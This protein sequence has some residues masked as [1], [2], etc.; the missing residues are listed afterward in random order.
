MAPAAEA[1]PVEAAHALLPFHVSV[2]TQ[3]GTTTLTA[4]EFQV[5][6]GR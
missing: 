2:A 3:I 5:G 1:A 6:S 4:D